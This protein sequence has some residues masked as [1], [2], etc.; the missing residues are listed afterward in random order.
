MKQVRHISL[1]V[2]VLTLWMPSA[3]FAK[4]ACVSLFG[5]TATLVFHKVKSIKKPG[6]TTPLQGV[7]IIGDA[8][9]AASGS[10]TMG[11]NG[12]V[13]FGVFVHSMDPVLSNNITFTVVGAP[14]FSGS[15]R[16]DSDGDF[17]PD[18]FVT[19]TP[20]DCKTVTIP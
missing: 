16:L 1:I 11:A 13:V 19:W 7:Y 8:K 15:G 5:G 12:E 2:A 14:D 20:I 10:A 9:A 3:A 4:D 18:G 17:L 6:K